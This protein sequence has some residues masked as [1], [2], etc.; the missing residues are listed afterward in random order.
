MSKQQA[1]RFIA[2]FAAE[3]IPLND[4]KGFI[5]V[6]DIELSS[7]HEGNLVRLKEL[8]QNQYANLLNPKLLQSAEE[9]HHD[10]IAQELLNYEETK[11][12]MTNE[13]LKAVC[14]TGNLDRLKELLQIKGVDI[15]NP[16]LLQSACQHNHTEIL[17]ELLKYEETDPTWDNSACIS[18]AVVKNN[19]DI[20]ELLLKKW[21]SRS[22]VF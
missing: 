12:V 6:I 18:I 9:N 10:E 8:L 17:Q 2:Q 5:E 4:Q 1:S 3:T 21:F 11:L 22:R 20:L 15:G 16:K 14:S 19:A 13:E 7:L